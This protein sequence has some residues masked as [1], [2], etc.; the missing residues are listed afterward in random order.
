[1]CVASRCEEL[2]RTSEVVYSRRNQRK[3]RSDRDRHP[4]VAY[5]APV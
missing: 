1:M 4:S 5:G 3:D 2:P